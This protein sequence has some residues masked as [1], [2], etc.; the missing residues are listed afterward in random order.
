VDLG[1]HSAPL[2]TQI[3]DGENGGV[4]MNE[5]PPKY[6]DVMREA[7]GSDTPAVNVSEYLEYL[8]AVGVGEEHFPQIQPL[9]QKRMWERFQQPAGPEALE[10]VIEE[11]RKQDGR[12]NVEGGSWTNNL[13]WVRGYES[14]L[15]PM[16]QV[17]ALFAQ[18]TQG[19]RT[20]DPR[21]RNAL[22]YLLTTQTSCYRYWGS[23]IWTDYGRELARRTNDI[24][25]YD[26]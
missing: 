14:V 17:S 26:F 18:K 21:Y 25:K 6:L 8:D 22:F 20:S 10:K 1:G 5:F 19:V 11:L 3:A 15:G 24:L 16:E 13:S 9:M 12:F 2:V 4:M 23:G 7:S